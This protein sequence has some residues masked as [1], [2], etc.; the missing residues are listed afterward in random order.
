MYLSVGE[1]SDVIRVLRPMGLKPPP[2]LGERGEYLVDL[3]A[4]P[5]CV[6]LRFADLHFGNT[7]SVP[8]HCISRTDSSMLSSNSLAGNRVSKQ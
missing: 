1:A 5:G 4:A 2:Q 6:S 3:V 8:Q 7:R